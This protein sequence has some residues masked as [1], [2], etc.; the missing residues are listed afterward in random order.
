M[1]VLALIICGQSAWPEL[2]LTSL[3]T[4]LSNKYR[5]NT[6]SSTTEPLRSSFYKKYNKTCLKR[7]LSKRSKLVLPIIT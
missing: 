2:I 4:G 1:K 3:F 7:P 5:Q 6:K